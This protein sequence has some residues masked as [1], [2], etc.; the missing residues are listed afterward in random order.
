MKQLSVWLATDTGM[1]P[2][3]PRPWALSCYVLDAEER[4]HEKPVTERFSPGLAIHVL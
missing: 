4:Q 3:R 1:P 2:F